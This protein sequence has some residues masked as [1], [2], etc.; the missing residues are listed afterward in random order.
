MS[1]A[2]T[3]FHATEVHGAAPRVRSAI[4]TLSAATAAAVIAS[5]LTA[6]VLSRGPAAAEERPAAVVSA[7]P[8]ATAATPGTS[9]PEASAAFKGKDTPVEEPAPTF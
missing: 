2:P 9:V 6:T 1:H 7:A 4:G 8:V 3:I 5:L